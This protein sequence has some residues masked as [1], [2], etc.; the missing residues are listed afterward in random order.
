MAERV[1]QTLANHARF[2]PPF[3]FFILPVFFIALILAIAHLVMH[4]SLHSAWLV[5]F[6]LAAAAAVVKMRT[7]SLKVQDRVIRLEERLR[8][9]ILL[10]KPLRARI[11]ELSESQLVG[12][13][14]ASDAELPALTARALQEKLSNA[15]IKKA[16][17]QWRPDYWRV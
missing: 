16:V 12:L 14:F 15:E 9:A 7:Y 11:T 8:L 10:D 5:I 1:P 17:I 4:P 13:R 2:D 6:T 3:H